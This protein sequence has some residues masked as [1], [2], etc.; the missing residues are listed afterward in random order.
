VGI[1]LKIS[2]QVY[3]LASLPEE[4]S[5]QYRLNRRLVGPQGWSPRFGEEEAILSFS[6]IE[7]QFVQPLAIFF[8]VV[9]KEP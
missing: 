6:A 8:H 1:G 3:T 2:G 9:R 4:K 5:Q 7:P